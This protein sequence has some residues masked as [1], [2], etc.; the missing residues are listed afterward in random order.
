MSKDAFAN[1][2]ALRS[3]SLTFTE[4]D[5]PKNEATKT[6]QEEID[7]A[8]TKYPAAPWSEPGSLRH[9]TIRPPKVSLSLDA[10]AT[11]LAQLNSLQE[12]YVY[13]YQSPPFTEGQV[14]LT[15]LTLEA[16][17]SSNRTAA[18]PPALHQLHPK[19]KSLTLKGYWRVA[20]DALAQLEQL[21]YLHFDNGR[22][23]DG[24]HHP[25]QLHPN[26]PL[27]IAAANGSSRP[28]YVDVLN[29]PQ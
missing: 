5:S 12:L 6:F 28:N 19:L 20:T 16:H 17:Y 15:T 26:S 14:N 18:Q 10:E 24:K 25:L 8:L 22:A 13:N 2:P 27:Y 4:P 9:L 11:P 29:L 7:Q 3:L 1:L 23:R 21:E